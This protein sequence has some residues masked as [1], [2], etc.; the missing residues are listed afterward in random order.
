MRPLAILYGLALLV[1]AL[2]QAQPSESA[3]PAP[4][5]G[6]AYVQKVD[7]VR[8]DWE[9]QFGTEVARRDFK[10]LRAY[11][12]EKQSELT[13]TRAEWDSYRSLMSQAQDADESKDGY[14]ATVQRLLRG[15]AADSV[16]TIPESFPLDFDVMLGHST[17]GEVPV[18]ALRDLQRRLTEEQ[19]RA[20]KRVV[21]VQSAYQTLTANVAT[22]E[23]DLRRAEDAI[24]VALAPEIENQKF[25][26][27]MSIIFSLL[28]AQLIGVFFFTIYR[29][30]GNDAGGLLLSD[31]GLQFVTIFVLI[32]AIVLFGI[33]NILE[34]RELAAILSGIA[35]YILGRG[36][37]IKAADQ[38][39]EPQPAA[40]APPPPSPMPEAAK[41]AAP[42]A[43]SVPKIFPEPAGAAAA[44]PGEQAQMNNNPRPTGGEE[45][46][47]G[48]AKG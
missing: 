48:E 15:V 13:A 3:D 21:A 1:P 34:G 43:V 32:I 16:I 28:I 9:V 29:K 44:A 45:D 12:A 10:R 42:A 46:D 8:S 39:A 14:I 22:L 23:R 27:T 37:R 25:R 11:L 33:L 30:S 6:A 41:N 2:L 20:E 18:T 17:P 38:P 31:G 4:G 35:G 5:S 24:D 47:P 19:N 40:G 26:R 36:A 7:S